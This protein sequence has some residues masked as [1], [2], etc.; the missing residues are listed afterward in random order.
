MPEMYRIKK[1]SGLP[2][3]WAVDVC[4]WDERTKRYCLNTIGCA[5][6]EEEAQEIKAEHIRERERQNEIGRS[7]SDNEKS[8]PV[9]C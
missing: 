8:P 1:Y 5:D 3:Q 4:E 7:E 9:D 6:T 2:K